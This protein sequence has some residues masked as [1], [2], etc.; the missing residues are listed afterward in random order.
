MIEQRMTEEEATKWDD[1]IRKSARFVTSDFP[2]VDRDDLIQETWVWLLRQRNMI[3][4]DRPGVLKNLTRRIRYLAWETRKE[5]LQRS[6]QYSYRTSDVRE[7]LE[8]L[9][10]YA[11]W[12]G[13]FVPRDAQSMDG[14][15]HMDAVDV[16]SD[17]SWAFST[18]SETY[19]QA[20]I[21]RYRDKRDPDVGTRQRK[22]LSRAVTRLTDRLNSYYRGVQRRR[23]ISN[24]QARALIENQEM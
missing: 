24:A 1:L 7:I 13:S 12:Q 21:S 16:R 6:A 14:L 11:D 19:R 23:A 22:S 9:F 8:T 2:D 17:I 3:D 15:G 18:L 10:N 4:P 5:Q 20:I